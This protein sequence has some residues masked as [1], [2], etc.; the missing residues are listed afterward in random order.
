M[1]WRSL[2]GGL[3]GKVG[4]VTGILWGRMGREG[5]WGRGADSGFGGI[6]GKAV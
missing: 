4:S 3:D 1:E 5:K 6:E 2:G